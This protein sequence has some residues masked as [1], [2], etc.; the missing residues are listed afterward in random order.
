MWGKP[1]L[2]IQ[3][4][5]GGTEVE[6]VVLNHVSEL[7]VRNALRGRQRLMAHPE[8]VLRAAVRVLRLVIQEGGQERYRA[9]W[10]PNR[11]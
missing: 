11:R 7:L 4:R 6:A 5:G 8:G 10:A 1:D 3:E 9:C 2:C